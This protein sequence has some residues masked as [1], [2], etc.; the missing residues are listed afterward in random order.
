MNEQT[1]RMSIKKYVTDM[2]LVK[3]IQHKGAQ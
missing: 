3:Q 2:V 1:M